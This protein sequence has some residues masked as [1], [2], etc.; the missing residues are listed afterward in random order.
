MLSSFGNIVFISPRSSLCSALLP[1]MHRNTVE[2]ILAGR[3]FQ[4]YYEARRKL[5][6]DRSLIRQ[7]N[8]TRNLSAKKPKKRPPPSSIPEVVLSYRSA[9]TVSQGSACTLEEKQPS[10]NTLEKR[11]SNYLEVES[12]KMQLSK[13]EGNKVLILRTRLDKEPERD[14]PLHERIK[15]LDEFLEAQSNGL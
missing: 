7:T 1:H 15:L 12:P 11:T 2:R 14:T 3:R 8:M 9:E 6:L 4:K 13:N 5:T 10:Q